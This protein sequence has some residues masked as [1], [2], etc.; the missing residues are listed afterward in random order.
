MDRITKQIADKL[1]GSDE[2]TPPKFRVWWIPQVPGKPF[3]AEVPDFKTARLVDETLGRYDIFQYE[4]R[5]KPDFANAGGIEYWDETE[6][7]WVGIDES[8]YA[9]WEDK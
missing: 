2:P 3:Y 5:I 4:N 9:E 1:Y 6:G 7:E 8:E